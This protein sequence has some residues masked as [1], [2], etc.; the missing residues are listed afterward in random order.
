MLYPDKDY[1]NESKVESSEIQELALPISN[2]LDEDKLKKLEDDLLCNLQEEL[3]NMLAV[4][5][6][7][8][9]VNNGISYKNHV[10]I[11]Q[12]QFDYLNG[13]IIEKN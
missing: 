12:K 3:K 10:D 2:M 5:K 11:L 13:E 1:I 9:D 7:D 8:T 6:T 4:N